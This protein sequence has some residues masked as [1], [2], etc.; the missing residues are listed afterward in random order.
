MYWPGN[1]AKAFV[2]DEV[3][4]RAGGGELTVLDHGCGSGGDWPAVLHDHPHLRLV[5]WDPHRPSA[6]AAARALDGKRATI[7]AGALPPGTTADVVVSFSVLE[8]VLDRVTYLR[9]A[10]EAL[11]PGGRF[12]LNYDDGHFR[13]PFDLDEKANLWPNAKVLAHNRLAP[14]LARVGQVHR[15][16]RRVTADEVQTLLAATGFE[17]ESSWFHNVE[18]LR[19]LAKT[20]PPDRAEAFARV[21]VEVETQLNESFGDVRTGAMQRG[22]DAALWQVAGSRTLL[23]R[24][25][26]G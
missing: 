19:R 2:I 14:L 5:G 9:Q 13:L 8:H 21:W 25:A 16:Q 12:F 18:S 6:E 23:L 3:L 4:R 11:A 15:F 22:D 26:C 17:V 20:M 7:H 10:R 24:P 1:S